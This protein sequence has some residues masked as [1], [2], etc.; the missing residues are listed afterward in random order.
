MHS[1]HSIH[2]IHVWFL[3]QRGVILVLLEP[4]CQVVGGAD[5]RSQVR[6][7]LIWSF[8]ISC[9]VGGR[10]LQMDGWL[11][12][13]YSRTWTWWRHR[14]C[15]VVMSGTGWT[16]GGVDHGGSHPYVW[17]GDQLGS[18]DVW[19]RC[20]SRFQMYSRVPFNCTCRRSCLGAWTWW[21][22]P[23]SGSARSRFSR[24]GATDTTWRGG[25]RD[26]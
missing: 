21:M 20:W 12:T 2:S 11:R 25:I 9:G 14:W 15:G 22:V 18:A 5:A 24:G 13:R 4:R 23:H 17:H 8:T 26:S 1:I 10:S 16:S 3:S 7:I 19:L 6:G